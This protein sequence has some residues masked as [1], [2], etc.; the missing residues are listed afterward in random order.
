MLLLLV[1]RSVL[2]FIILF[3]SPDGE[4]PEPPGSLPVSLGQFR[5]DSTGIVNILTTTILTPAAIANLRYQFSNAKQGKP[6]TS[7]SGVYMDKRLVGAPWKESREIML[8]FG[9]KLMVWKT[10]NRRPPNLQSFNYV[11]SIPID[12]T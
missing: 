2:S 5:P 4:R 1:N 8:E 10:L 3:L 12:T 7:K 9:S 6:T 11:P